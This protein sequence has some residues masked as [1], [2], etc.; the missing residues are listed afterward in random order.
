MSGYPLAERLGIS[1]EA[2]SREGS[3]GEIVEWYLRTHPQP[4]FIVHAEMK[5]FVEVTELRMQF[6]SPEDRRLTKVTRFKKAVIVPL[7]GGIV[8]HV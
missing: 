4:K 6:P 5:A 3:T 1:M 2:R 7:F 8:L